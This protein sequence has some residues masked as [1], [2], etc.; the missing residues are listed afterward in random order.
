MSLPW[1]L[2][3]WRRLHRNLAVRHNV[4]ELWLARVVR[5][6][7]DYLVYPRR[8]FEQTRNITNN[9]SIELDPRT[10]RTPNIDGPIID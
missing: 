3:N 9:D 1:W 4:N 6:Y 7:D 5:Q 10:N 2:R 8:K